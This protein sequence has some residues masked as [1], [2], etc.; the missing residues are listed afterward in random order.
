[1]AGAAGV[2]WAWKRRAWGLV[3]YVVTAVLGCL[4]F[5][6]V[7]SPWIGGKTLAI[8]SPALLAAA[9]AGCAAVLARGRVVEAAVLAA[10]IAGGVLWSNALAVPRRLARPARRSCTSSRRSATSSRVRGPR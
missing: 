1:M 7:S 9:F 8:A 4:V 5:V 10:A 2:W 6:G 3:V